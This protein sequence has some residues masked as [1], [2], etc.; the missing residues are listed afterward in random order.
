MRCLPVTDPH[1]DGDVEDEQ[2]CSKSRELLNRRE[3]RDSG[4]TEGKSE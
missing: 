4:C 1:H 3:I 2:R